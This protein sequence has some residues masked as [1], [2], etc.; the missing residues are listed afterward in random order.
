MRTISL[1][2][3]LPFLLLTF[4]TAVICTVPVRGQSGEA[5][6]GTVHTVT[7]DP[8]V[9]VSVMIQGEKEGT[10]TDERGNFSLR[11]KT[12]T[13]LVITHVGY[14]KKEV[15]ARDGMEV[16][17]VTNTSDLS[18]VLVVGYG[19]QSRKK[20]TGAVST[21]NGDD[22]KNTPAV[23]FDAMLQ[24][25]IPGVTVQSSS[26]EPGARTNIVIRG[27]TNVDY[28]NV[29][30]GNTQPLYVIDG[31]IYDLNNMQGSYGL[32]NPLSVIDPN[33]IES[34]DV[35]KDASAAAIYGAR[36]GNGVIIV[37]TR[38]SQARRPSVSLNAY[39]GFTTGPRLIDVITGNAERALKMQLLNGQL[40]Y[41]DI[42]NGSIPIQLTDSLNAAFNNDVNWQG[43]ML[44][45]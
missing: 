14:N 31:V 29:N 21:I 35:L 11:V 32:S 28:G 27:S 20:I 30:G 33:D 40:P 12:G 13:L 15:E 26:G 45:L 18:Q 42:Y 3:M 22:I 2:K 34:I 41:T 7:G 19:S 36:G 4:L 8:L 17:L 1:I 9:G 44:L 6:H 38:R 24:G 39:G 25:R 43:M 16:V 5:V 10:L 37:K 23:S